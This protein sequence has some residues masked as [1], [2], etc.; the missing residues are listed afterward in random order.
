MKKDLRKLKTVAFLVIISELLVL[1]AFGIFYFSDFFGFKEFIDANFP[2]VFFSF[3]GLSVIN[4][5]LI[6]IAILRF[7]RIRSRSDL[8]TA[9]LLGSDIQ[10]AYNFGMIG[11]IV[12]DEKDNILWVNRFF[13][14]RQFTILDENIITW[15]K[16]L[17]K[18]KNL[19]TDQL[20]LTISS[21]IYNVKYIAEAGLYI[22]QD[23]TDYETSI[24]DL[25]QHK[26]VLG[27]IQ[28]DNYSEIARSK[29]S[30][31]ITNI[32][33]NVISDFARNFKLAIR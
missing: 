30:I 1:T 22:F 14:E 20:K 3:I 32:L 13:E 15:Q 8:Y 17:L 7:S 16:D 23:V 19:E 4:F 2:I 33:R 10:E 11:L 5:V 9:S 24:H 29:D 18:L 27:Y 12:V 31:E 6:W 26:I 21:R 25:T 28:I